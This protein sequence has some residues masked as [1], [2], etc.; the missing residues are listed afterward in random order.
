MLKEGREF[1]LLKG[2][3]PRPPVPNVFP[4]GVGNIDA[5]NGLATPVL[6]DVCGLKPTPVVRPDENGVNPLEVLDKPP[7]PVG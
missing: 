4:V 2:E 5:R 7:N 6:S 1:E 3:A